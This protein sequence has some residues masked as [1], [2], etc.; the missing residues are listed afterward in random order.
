MVEGALWDTRFSEQ[1]LDA[2][3]VVALLEQHLCA[4]FEEGFFGGMDHR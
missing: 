1:A 3:G 2:Q 4:G